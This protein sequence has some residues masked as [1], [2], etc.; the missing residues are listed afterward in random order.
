MISKTTVEEKKSQ[1]SKKVKGVNECSPG[2]PSLPTLIIVKANLYHYHLKARASHFLVNLLFLLGK[3][4][5]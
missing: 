5:I 3:I 2:T 4:A 1:T